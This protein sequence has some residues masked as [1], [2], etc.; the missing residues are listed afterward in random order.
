MPSAYGVLLSGEEE[1][2]ITDWFIRSAF[3]TG[4]QV[5]RLL[6]ALE[7]GPEEGC[8]EAELLA[9]LNLAKG[10]LQQ[11]LKILSLETPAPIGKQGS[12]WQR[13]PAE[14]QPAFWQRVERLTELRRAETEQMQA[15]VDL[16]FGEHMA[17]LIEALDGDPSAV[18]PPTLPPLP[19]AVP[20]D[21]A[22]EAGS[23][24][25]HLRITIEPRKK[26]P[27]GGLRTFGLQ[28]WR[29]APPPTW[30]TCIPSRRHPELV[31]AFAAQL[32]SALGLPFVS[33]LKKVRDT[34]EQKAMQNS[35]Q[36]ARNLAAELLPP[37]SLMSAPSANTQAVLLLTS[38]LLQE[39]GMGTRKDPVL[40]ASEYAELA[41]R[42][43]QERHE[44][45]DLING[46]RQTL[47]ATLS[48]SFPAERLDNLLSRGFQLSQAVE[49]W[50][51]RSI[52]VIGR[53]DLFY[54]R[55][56]KQRLKRSAPPLL[57]AC[58]NLDLLHRPAL[59]VVGARST[60]EALLQQAEAVGALAAEAGV[61][62]ASAAAKGVDETAMLG[63][64][65]AGGC[66]I[67]VVA[68]SLEKVSARPIWRQAL[69][70]GR[71]L[72]LSSDAPSAR[73]QV[74]RAMGR[75]KL[76]YALADAALVVSST[77]GEGGT[78]A[79]ATE[80]LQCLRF[81]P[82]HVLSDPRGGPGLAALAE[83]RCSGSGARVQEWRK[84]AC[85]RPVDV[86]RCCQPGLA[87]S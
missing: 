23:F 79:G 78:W 3:P 41:A 70:E 87:E 67:G 29:P 39:G 36:Q 35:S 62:I 77:K 51:N 49:H 18:G 66:A 63:S 40:S 45:A 59:A 61:V 4:E 53:A 80:Q 19:E 82:V 86:W 44:P 85:L 33:A 7:H 84:D 24:L 71:L 10:R 72:L 30:V 1:L 37:Q 26:W 34:A 48:E 25:R 20:D 32:A 52:T 43:Q 81:C 2:A 21:L 76:I 5:E 28:Q 17:F 14:L 8:T 57:Y 12:R 56:F 50:A 68:D 55:R 69:L 22:R 6:E 64:L 13:L 27:T 11:A 58:G 46:A 75:N 38:P 31:P 16:P 9:Q 74:W 60:P 47:L 83:S 42:L 73:F 15:Y 65:A 54:P